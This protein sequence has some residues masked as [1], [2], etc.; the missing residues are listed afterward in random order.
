M[1]VPVCLWCGTELRLVER[2][3]SHEH[4]PTCDDCLLELVNNYAGSSRQE[5]ARTIDA[6]LRKRSDLR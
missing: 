5:R 4:A 2:W 3:S 1:F 6:A